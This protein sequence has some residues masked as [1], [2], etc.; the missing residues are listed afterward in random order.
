MSYDMPR[1][2]RIRQEEYPYHATTRTNGRALLFKKWT[3][4]IIIGVLTEATR[5]YD[6][7]IEHFKMMDNHYHIKLT[8]PSSN[9]DRVMWFIN[10][11]I[12][13]RINRHNGVT[14]HL[15]G[16]RYHATIVQ[17]DDYAE[18]CVRYI[19]NNGV[20]AGLCR[21]ASEDERFSTFDFYAKGEKV[22]F[23]VTEDSVY[24]ML[25]E[26][27]LERQAQFIA[28]MDA[29]ANPMEIEAIRMGLKK[30]FYGSADFIE[31]MKAR[32][33]KH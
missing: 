33:L 1:P 25:G 27:R 6:V 30:M 31:Q 2:H 5:R 24:L 23:T 12:A 21:R 28:M 13:K 15:W 8:T 17:N 14:G 20:K 18:R 32:Y 16:E 11:Q 10:N 9:I 3:Y 19:Y 4:K 26:D 29:P 22:E 7:Q